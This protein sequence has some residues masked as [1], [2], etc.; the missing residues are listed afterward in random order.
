MLNTTSLEVIG[1]LIQAEE[2]FFKL[3]YARGTADI[4]QWKSL[5]TL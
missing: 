1:I 2:L 4:F 3:N 5:N